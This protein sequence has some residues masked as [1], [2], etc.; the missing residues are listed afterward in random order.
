MAAAPNLPL[1]YARAQTKDHTNKGMAVLS[2]P[3]AV[4]VESGMGST[5]RGKREIQDQRAKGNK[6][7]AFSLTHS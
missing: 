3:W 1:P 4:W 7:Q 5:W 2:G 6:E